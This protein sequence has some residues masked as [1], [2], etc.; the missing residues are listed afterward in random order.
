MKLTLNL[1]IRYNWFR[2]TFRGKQLHCRGLKVNKRELE[3]V[4]DITTEREKG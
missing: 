3:R 1:Y 2:E 4:R